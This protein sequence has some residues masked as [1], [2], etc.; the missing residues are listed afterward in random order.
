MS[1]PTAHLDETTDEGHTAAMARADG[2]AGQRLQ[3]LPRPLVAEALRRPAT[4]RIVVTDCGYFPHAVSHGRRRPRGAAQAIVILVTEGSGWCVL[5]GDRVPVRRGQVL[6]V[7]PGEPHEYGAD[8]DT[9]WT[10]WWMHVT[11]P[12]VGELLRAARLSV[13]RPVVALRE[14]YAAAALVERALERL[15]RD[16]SVPSLVAAS[17][18]AWHLLAL[19]A[20]DQAAGRPHDDPVARVTEYLQLHSGERTSVADLAALVGLSASRLA[21]LFRRQTGTSILAYQTRQRMSRARELLDTTDLP[22]AS[23]GR[24]VGYDDPYYFSRHFHKIHGMSPSFYRSH[25]KG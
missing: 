12:D 21:E 6:V 18:A 11:G 25:D 8:D 17:G 4:S 19:L 15:E 16:D 3:V 10:I 7:P 9:P 13:A 23:V 22:V 14:P 24:A 20:A 5:D 2:F 1:V